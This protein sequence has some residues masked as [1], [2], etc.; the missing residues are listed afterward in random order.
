MK[1]KTSHPYAV[2]QHWLYS[3]AM[4]EWTIPSEDMRL[5]LRQGEQLSSEG[6]SQSPA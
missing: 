6:W 5:Q 1:S 4:I 3:A 2:L